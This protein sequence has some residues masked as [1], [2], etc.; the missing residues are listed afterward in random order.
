M[1]LARGYTTI[2]IGFYLFLNKIMSSKR[3]VQV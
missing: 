1:E 3:E 2:K